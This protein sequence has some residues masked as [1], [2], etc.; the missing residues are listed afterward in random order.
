MT[1]KKSSG[2][3]LQKVAWPLIIFY[4]SD[5]GKS[6][7]TSLPESFLYTAANVSNLYSV[8]LRSFG[9][10]KTYQLKQKFQINKQLSNDYYILSFLINNLQNQLGRLSTKL[11]RNLHCLGLPQP[12]QNNTPLNIDPKFRWL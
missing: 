12:F 8:L 3:K 11:F 10:R 1:I 7:T 2:M 6:N 5:T 4:A 9:S